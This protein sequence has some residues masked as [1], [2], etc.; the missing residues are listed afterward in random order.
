[1][2]DKAVKHYLE[3]NRNPSRYLKNEEKLSYWISAQRRNAMRRIGIMKFNHI[4]ELWCKLANDN[5]EHFISDSDRWKL[6]LDNVKNYINDADK[7]PTSNS[8]DPRIKKMGGWLDDQIHN[9]KI[10]ERSFL[11]DETFEKWNEFANDEKY[12]KY[13]MTNEEK[14]KLRLNDVK[15]MIIEN[16]RR[17]SQHSKIKNEKKLGLWLRTQMKDSKNR[18]NILKSEEI[19]KKWIEFIEDDEFKKY[20]LNKHF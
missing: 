3:E 7:K 19:Y 16:G 13:F 18:K 20:F 8:K 1:M 6:T 11:S 4:H 5:I 17:P 14:W 9:T 12:M 15:K 2:Y 10:R